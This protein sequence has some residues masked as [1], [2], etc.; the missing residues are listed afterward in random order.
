[1]A[2]WNAHMLL[3][4]DIVARI[5]KDFQPSNVDAAITL[6]ENSGLHGRV[7]RCIIF[8]ANRRFDR[9]RLYTKQACLDHRDTIA[10]AEYDR[11]D[12]RLRDFTVSF[13]IDSPAKMWI[14]D[15]AMSMQVCEYSLISIEAT[16]DPATFLSDS[17]EE[18]EGMALFEGD[19]GSITVTKK[20]G[21][22]RM[23]HD[24][25]DLE[26]YGVDR[27]FAE[28]TE[29]RDTVSSYIARKRNPRRASTA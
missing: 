24:S 1:M 9:L 8:A 2:Q 25:R 7:A 11:S 28:Q 27:P 5:K 21:W 20:N 16:K 10:A 15:I 17:G 19:L 23:D 4:P 6:L 22:L 14:S 13:L 26:T 29:F 3:E 12:R 18:G